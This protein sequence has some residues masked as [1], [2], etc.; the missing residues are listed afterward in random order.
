MVVTHCVPPCQIHNLSYFTARYIYYAGIKLLR[1]RPFFEDTHWVP[2][3]MRDTQPCFYAH[4][5]SYDP[6]PPPPHLPDD[7]RRNGLRR[8]T[9]R[10]SEV[11]ILALL[12]DFKGHWS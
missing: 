12:G 8:A 3:R 10:R 6:P 4:I 1:K 5:Y 9:T 7:A 11:D 2:A